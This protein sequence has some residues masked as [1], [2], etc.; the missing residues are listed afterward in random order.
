MLGTVQKCRRLQAY[1]SFSLAPAVTFELKGGRNIDNS[2]KKRVAEK[3]VE[4]IPKIQKKIFSALDIL[5]IILWLF[6]GKLK[7]TSDVT[8]MHVCFTDLSF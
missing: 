8:G 4:A 1:L 5:F 7:K 3:N 2:P 6:K